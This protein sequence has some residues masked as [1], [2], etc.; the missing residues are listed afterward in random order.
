MAQTEICTRNSDSLVRRR[1]DEGG[2]GGEGKKNTEEG[3]EKC[4]S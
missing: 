4:D 3:K 2:G 1:K